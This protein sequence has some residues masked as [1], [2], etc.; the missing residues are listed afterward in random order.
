MNP[1]FTIQPHIARRKHAS[2]SS[3]ETSL[4]DLTFNTPLLEPWKTQEVLNKLG[5]LFTDFTSLF[6]RL[7]REE[8]PGDPGFSLQHVVAGSLP[9]LVHLARGQ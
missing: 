1:Q 6:C 4:L 8:A 3:G 5:L 9:D 2:T 7:R